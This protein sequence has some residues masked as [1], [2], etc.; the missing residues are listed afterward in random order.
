MLLQPWLRDHIRVS[1]TGSEKVLHRFNRFD[2]RS[3]GTFPA[4][5]LLD[6]NGILYGTTGE[7]GGSGC[8][9]HDGCGTVYS[10]S[11]TGSQTVL[12]RFGRGADGAVPLGSLINVNGTLYG[13][14]LEGGS[15]G[16]GR[17]IRLRNCLQ[18]NQNRHGEGTA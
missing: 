17:F 18:H 14:T 8:N 3:H 7:G 2:R 6:V 9:G 1:T 12:H 4:S 11:T 16:Y 15:F 5:G 10:V 13:T